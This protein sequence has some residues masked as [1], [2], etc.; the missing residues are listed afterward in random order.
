M[1]IYIFMKTFKKYVENKDLLEVGTVPPG[2]DPE[3]WSSPSYQKF[4]LAQNQQQAS[5]PPAAKALNQNVSQTAT[6]S[7]GASDIDN[8]IRTYLGRL[9][10]MPNE[11]SLDELKKYDLQLATE[12]EKGIRNRSIIVHRN[13]SDTFGFRGVSFFYNKNG[14]VGFI[15]N[16]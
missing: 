4:W 2:A 9:Q 13:R 5:P 3:M 6:K 15:V 14:R 12:V 7:P 1:L 10:G 16:R 11:G 8:A